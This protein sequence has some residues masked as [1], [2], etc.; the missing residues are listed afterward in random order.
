MK[1][2]RLSIQAF[3]PFATKEDVLF[4]SFGENPLFLINGATGAG[5]STIL[6][7]ICVALYGH[8]TGAE[9]EAGQ[10]RCDYADP[11]TITEL[12]LEF[13]I[14]GKR[15][16]VQR[17]PQQLRPKARG[18]GTTLQGAE[19]NLWQFD[20]DGNE[21]LI[22]AKKVGEVNEHI[23]E[24]TGLNVEQFRQVMVL[25]Q[26]KF[27]ELLLADSKQREAI[28]G[29]LFQTHIYRRIEEG[30][31]QKASAIRREAEAQKHRIE[32]ILQNADVE[33]EQAL[34]VLVSELKAPLEQAETAKNDKQ[35]QLN[36][37]KLQQEEAEKT[38]QQ[39]HRLAQ[40]TEALNQLVAGQTE[41]DAK[42]Q[43]LASARQ[44][45]SLAPA[46]QLQ[47][48]KQKDVDD[49]KLAIQ[50]CYAEVQSLTEKLA[51]AEAKLE[52]A[53]TNALQIEPLS[54]TLLNLEQCASDVAAL[55]SVRAQ[56]IQSQSLQSRQELTLTD[57]EK[58]IK[59]KKQAVKK[60][61]DSNA[62]LQHQ[63]LS[64]PSVHQAFSQWQANLLVAKQSQELS[65]KLLAA[66]S[67]GKQAA[68]LRQQA[69]VYR[70]ECQQAL[71]QLEIYWH[72]GQAAMLAEQLNELQPCPVCGSTEHPLPAKLPDGVARVERAQVDQAR[73][74]LDT[75][76]N[77]LLDA[78]KQHAELQQHWRQLKEQQQTLLSQ[79]ADADC[80]SLTLNEIQQKVEQLSNQLD[81]LN[82][83]QQQ[84]LQQSEALKV[85]REL[86]AGLE[87]KLASLQ[88]ELTETQKQTALLMSEK[89]R[90]EALLPEELKAEGALEQRIAELKQN[91]ET[92]RKQLEAAAENKQRVTSELD[93]ASSRLAHLEQQQLAMNG[94]LE[95]AQQAWTQALNESTFEHSEAFS[96]AR[97]APE[98]QQ[99]LATEIETFQKNIH[100]LTAQKQHIQQQLEGIVEP[101]LQMLTIQVRDAQTQFSE[102]ERRWQ[103]LHQRLSHLEKTANDL[104]RAHQESAD[105]E[106]QYRIY[107]TLSDV[108]NGMTGQKISLQRFV[109]SV[110]LDDV[111]IQAS[112]RLQLMSKG[113]YQL[114]RKEDRSKGN[115]ASGLELEVEDA[116]TGKT[117]SVAT[118]SGGESFMAALALALGVSDVVQEYAGGIKLDTLF[119]DE[120]FGSLDPESL[121]LAI[122]TL[123]DL[124]RS[125][126]M[127]G[128]I[129]H[130]S[131]LKEQM[132]MRLDIKSTQRGSKVE[133][134]TL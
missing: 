91:L 82:Q 34:Q 46:Y 121:D 123:I 52:Q 14:A 21:R 24:I 116:Y 117:R 80:A 94:E 15:Y 124:Q 114:I 129:S 98:Q 25:P 8:T 87:E 1:P 47:Q 70:D 54:R 59:K 35:K 11:D 96:A 92:L 63:L 23:H 33:S 132:A 89:Q 65:D 130:V 115:R 97:M 60:L 53:Q 125:G 83:Y 62:S 104:K 108:A 102:A 5:K 45:D 40:V 4:E 68:V 79:L 42:Q 77:R 76:Q 12:E 119:I 100:E 78:E 118:L 74:V 95:N 64:Q 133:M 106:A 9:R 50:Q 131:E 2:L 19:A 32:G 113:R 43:A 18:E 51:G 57:A 128:I 37:A 26:G 86:I 127:I 71:T 28:F 17:R 81:Q 39:F 90:L 134:V 22:A 7:A 48:I 69:T 93:K 126:R 44:A 109:L 56:L 16:R 13:S 27:R 20:S 84:S 31:K 110:L 99:I 111:L 58:Q 72:Q 67:N 66:E 75:S 6:D 122:R 3:G 10:M 85:E 120:G 55:P 36:K 107:G 38:K 112:Q 105:I 30:L 88:V 103:Q 73:Q 61:E 41:M 49:G 101:D 29:Q